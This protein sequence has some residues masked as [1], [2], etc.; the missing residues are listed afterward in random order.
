MNRR[1][2]ETLLREMKFTNDYLHL[3]AKATVDISVLIARDIAGA[4]GDPAL[5]NRSSAIARTMVRDLQKLA[6]K[7]TV[8]P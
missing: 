7:R 4:N 6:D 2:F 1:T 8:R 3:V 5:A